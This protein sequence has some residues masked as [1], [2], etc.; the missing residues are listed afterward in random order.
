MVK[1]NKTRSLKAGSK[2]LSTVAVLMLLLNHNHMF[3]HNN[4]NRDQAY[5]SPCIEAGTAKAAA[6]CILILK[7]E[8]SRNKSRRILKTDGALPV[9]KII[10]Y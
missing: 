5:Y 10:L 7:L 8:E 6:A 9:C 1:L 4:G 3:D 2:I